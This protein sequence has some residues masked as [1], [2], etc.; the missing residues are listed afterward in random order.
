MNNYASF[1]LNTF[2]SLKGKHVTSNDVISVLLSK[3]GV[4]SE[5]MQATQSVVTNEI[6]NKNLTL[7]IG[8]NSPSVLSA[9]FLY[10]NTDSAQT[11]KF[12]TKANVGKS[13]AFVLLQMN[14][15]FAL[16]N[17]MQIMVTANQHVT[18][19]E[20]TELTLK[21][22]DILAAVLTKMNNQPDEETTSVTLCFRDTSSKK[23]L[24]YWVGALL[25]LLL[26]AILFYYLMS[27]DK[28]ANANANAAELDMQFY[29]FF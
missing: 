2:Q 18:I 17:P 7:N 28:K 27:G 29:N 16:S 3:S 19:N 20:T 1:I 14:E 26:L 13:N 9:V 4:E 23:M 10:N 8:L 15:N 21:P 11:L 22:K 12:C 6:K 25:V 5:P 24:Y